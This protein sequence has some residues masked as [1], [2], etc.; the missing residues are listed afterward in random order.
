MKTE[1]RNHLHRILLVFYLFS[2]LSL[3]ISHSHLSIHPPANHNPSLGQ[4]FGSCLE[5]SSGALPHWDQPAFSLQP[6]LTTT[7][8]NHLSHPA[9][10]RSIMLFAPSAF[11]RGRLPRLASVFRPLA[12]PLAAITSIPNTLSSRQQAQMRG[13][14]VRSSVK[15]LCDGCMVRQPQNTTLLWHGAPHRRILLV[16]VATTLGVIA[17]FCF[18]RL[19]ALAARCPLEGCLA[20]ESALQQSVR[21]K[22]RVYIICSKNQ[23][24]KQRQG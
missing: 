15:K 22:N 17:R 20:D 21:R 1:D 11:L 13:M 3:R 24:H 9:R 12:S 18:S 14:K 16:L 23:K 4:G 5:W 7:T 6:H 10:A 19:L 8:A 2:F